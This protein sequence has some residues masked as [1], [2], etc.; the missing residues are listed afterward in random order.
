MASN[1]TQA[2]VENA[3]PVSRG[4]E[5]FDGGHTGLTA[6]AI[7]ERFAVQEA[8]ATSLENV[9]DRLARNRLY[10]RGTTE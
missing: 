6:A 9:A 7:A 8:I 4:A 10:A 3:V 2:A 5:F 1:V